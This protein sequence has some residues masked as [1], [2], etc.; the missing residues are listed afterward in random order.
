M[1]TAE[2]AVTIPALVLVLALCLGAVQ[3]LSLIHI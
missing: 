2:A 1:V 3:S